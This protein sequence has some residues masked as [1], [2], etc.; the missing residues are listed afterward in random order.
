MAGSTLSHNGKTN[1]NSPTYM[2]DLAS[3]LGIGG[4]SVSSASSSNDAPR[5][6]HPVRRSAGS[7]TRTPASG[8]LSATS[9]STRLARNSSAA[10]VATGSSRAGGFSSERE[11]QLLVLLEDA[12]YLRRSEGIE[13]LRSMLREVA[14]QPEHGA[15]FVFSRPKELYSLIKARLCDPSWNVAHQTTLMVSELVAGLPSRAL[16]GFLA[17]ALPNIVHNLGDS[18]ILI[19]KESLQ[20]L[21]ALML[22][23]AY[24]AVGKNVVTALVRHGLLN[25]DL[26]VR[27][28]TALAI[29]ALVVGYNPAIDFVQLIQA[30][31]GRL[32]DG[33]DDVIEAAEQ[34]LYH[35]RLE[36]KSGFDAHLRRLTPQ[37]RKAYTDHQALSLPRAPLG[38]VASLNASGSSVELAPAPS[39]VAPQQPQPD[40]SSPPA[41]A[42]ASPRRPATPDLA[43]GL[44]PDS[45]VAALEN[46][47]DWQTRASA[48][49]QL[50]H[51]LANVADVTTLLPHLGPLIRV[52]TGPLLHDANFTIALTTLESLSELVHRAGFHIN[53][54]VPGVLVSLFN[55]LGDSKLV[56][57]TTVMAI[58]M[59]LMA[60]VTPKPILA[61]LLKQLDHKSW[62]VRCDIVDIVIAAMLTFSDYTFDFRVLVNSLAKLLADP[63]ERVAVLTL[64]AFALMESRTRGNEILR[65][66]TTKA[67]AATLHAVQ[68]RC[69]APADKLAVLGRNGLPQLPFLAPSPEA[70]DMRPRRVRSAKVAR[71]GS[72]SRAPLA[73]HPHDS[74]ATRPAV[75]RISPETTADTAASQPPRRRRISSA[76]RERTL[77]P[78]T[79]RR[80]P[81]EM[82]SRSRSQTRAATE[83]SSSSP[84]PDPGSHRPRPASV[85]RQGS[86]P[87]AMPWSENYPRRRVSGSVAQ[88]VPSLSASIGPGVTVGRTA[89]RR[90]VGDAAWDAFV[91]HSS[92]SSAAPVRSASFHSSSAGPLAPSRSPDAS[93]AASPPPAS[94]NRPRHFSPPPSSAPSSSASNPFSAPTQPVNVGLASP[95]P[96]A[97][98]PPARVYAPDFEYEHETS[99][100]DD[101]SATFDTGY[102]STFDADNYATRP[103]NDSSLPSVSEDDGDDDG[104][105][106]S[107]NAFGDG[108]DDGDDD[109]SYTYTDDDS[110]GDAGYNPARYAEPD[111]PISLY[112]CNNCGRKFNAQSLARHEKVCQSVFSTKRK[113]F[114]ATGGNPRPA[115]S[116]PTTQPSRG[117]APAREDPHPAPASP[118]Q[119]RQRQRQRQPAPETRSPP[120]PARPL[121]TPATTAHDERPVAA[122]KPQGT[123]ASGLDPE[124]YAP[125]PPADQLQACSIC[126]RTFAPHRIEKHET[127][128]RKASK[129][130]K[131]LSGTKRRRDLLAAEKS[132]KWREQHAEFIALVRNAKE[133]TAFEKAGGKLSD[134]PPPS[135]SSSSSSLVPCPHCTRKFSRQAAERHIPI[136]ANNE[137][138]PRPPPKT[139]RYADIARNRNR[140]LN[141]RPKTIT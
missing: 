25:S 12:S 94:R 62:R 121:A 29:P 19:R 106:L 30:L 70:A 38:S 129:A 136:C 98:T 34:A 60:I 130:R 46:V 37:Q 16:P 54:H 97:S 131:P 17:V 15:H 61:Y 86:V 87:A 8:S 89:S 95:S 68:D 51:A 57:R 73:I 56:I 24:E 102:N 23:S 58:M 99:N 75:E 67:D 42:P 128:C 116:R 41:T 10:S 113:V 18:K 83:K 59:R 115:S 93:P 50:K 104:D 3:S 127:A 111:S 2:N 35:L 120:E 5:S 76:P 110:S 49:E 88:P 33:S 43:F 133:V 77:R 39:A 100:A 105:T 139:N 134:L 135:P 74:S 103:T 69:M 13:M 14:D 66:L 96:A 126:G 140:P 72:V 85:S 71:P 137:N 124:A 45:V 31:I 109:D 47:D 53:T 22:D 138:K 79:P 122:A 101:L 82:G 119:P 36:L 65:M 4:R 117:P 92:L 141:R 9:S 63:H 52:L 11:S 132:T 55:K 20:A 48:L 107:T 6:A 118:Q 84:K 80:L 78:K 21:S 90:R 81:W 26:R 64:E 108:V 114:N 123:P 44:V 1:S 32:T 40:V 125:P 112:P 27:L 7:A 91:R 28:E